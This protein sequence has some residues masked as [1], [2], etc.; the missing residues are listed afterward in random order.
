MCRVTVLIKLDD[1]LVA[2]RLNEIMRSNFSD[3]VDADEVFQWDTAL[4]HVMIAF[5]HYIGSGTRGTD[6]LP[7]EML[8]RICN[9]IE[10][11]VY[12]YGEVWFTFW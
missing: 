5:H 10:D 6:G 7:E 2:I 1:K 3:L 4:S 8:N 11:L 9:A 12:L